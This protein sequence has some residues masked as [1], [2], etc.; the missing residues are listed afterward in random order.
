M[1]IIT[2]KNLR[3]HEECLDIDPDIIN[4][5]NNSF[6]N[7]KTFTHKNFKYKNQ[8]IK[9]ASSVLKNPKIQSIK[10][11]ISNKVNLIL[12]KLSENNLNNLVIEFIENIKITTIEHYNEF[13]KTIY[14]K[15]LSEINFIKNYL[16][17]FILI[18]GTFSFL[19][20][21][22][23]ETNIENNINIETNV[24]TNIESNIETD[25][26]TNNYSSE[27]NIKYFFNL[28]EYKFKYEYENLQL[29]DE[30]LFLIDLSHSNNLKLISELIKL[31]YMNNNFKIFIDEYII[32]QKVYLADI[33][34]WFK[35]S[36][37]NENQINKIKIILKDDIQ[38]RDKVLLENLINDNNKLVFKNIEIK[39]KQINKTIPTFI[40]E[41]NKIIYKNHEKN[42]INIYELDNILEEYFFINNSDSIDYY[43]ETNCKDTVSKN[44]LCEYI[45]DKYF[46]IENDKIFILFKNLI[47]KKLLFKSNLSRGLLNIYGTLEK[48]SVDFL[49]KK[50]VDFLEKKYV[51]TLEK[52]S[53]N[54]LE[55]KSGESFDVYKIKKMLIFLKNQGITNGLEHLISKYIN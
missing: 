36:K 17:F 45:I 51:N 55:K 3:Y 28:I 13:L 48:K 2:F 4:T 14:I 29:D 1:N 6:L 44:K 9:K 42:Q 32:N 22:N 23:I 47:R 35:D 26:E 50:S 52:K 12:N 39:P 25:I 24:E 11:K 43:I 21:M 10:D 7:Y 54:T 37:L 19:K 30:Y 5:I 41:N 49:E 16:N 40:P 8:N 46:K 38:L 15:I 18:S 27:Y 34:E 31:N 53:V 20:K 33:W